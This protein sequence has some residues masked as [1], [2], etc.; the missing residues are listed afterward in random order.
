MVNEGT[1]PR[2]SRPGRRDAGCRPSAG[3][4]RPRAACACGSWTA[5]PWASRAIAR[6]PVSAGG[7]C[8]AGL[9]GLQELVHPDRLRTPMR[10]TGARGAGS[11]KEISWDE[12][13]DEIAGRLRQLREQGRP[14]AFAVLE[15]GDSPLTHA[16]LERVMGAYG[17]PNLVLDGHERGVA[18]RVELHRRRRARSGRRPCAF[19]LHPELRPRAVRDR[20]P[21][22]VAEQGVGPVCALRRCSGPPRSPGSARASPRAHR[23]PTCASPS[24]RVKRRRWPSGSCTSS[25]WKTWST[26]RS[27]SAGPTGSPRRGARPGREGFESFVTQALH[28]GG[29]EPPHGGARRARSCAWAARSA[30]RSARSRSSARPRCT[31]EDALATGVRR[32]RAQPGAGR[33]GPRGRLRCGRELAGRAARRA[34][35]PDA[36]ARTGPRGAARGR[37]RHRDAR[38]RQAQPGERLVANLAAGQALSDRRAVRARRESRCTSGR[39]ASRSRRRSRAFRCWWRSAG[40]PDETAALADIVLP[41]SSFLESWNLLPSVARAAARS[42][43]AAAAG[44]PAALREPRLRGHVVRAR[45]PRRRSHGGSGAGG[46][47]RRLA[48]RRPPR[49]CSARVAARSRP[50]RRASASRASSRRAA[51]RSRV[52]SP[53]AAFWTALRESAGWV[54]SPAVAR[55]PCEVLGRGSERFSF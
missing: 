40:V 18:R 30:R 23:A 9:A 10:R 16:W 5:C 17:S 1:L 14:Q 50:A 19:G 38:R 11:W 4:A 31:R 54:D 24:A 27:S 37:C 26:A 42:R 51:G 12:A 41:E 7:L 3:C 28:A 22:G 33:R 47:V 20:R 15:R 55:S 13:L 44:G 45:A 52:R 53:A 39:T 6:I 2:A 46:N 32:G 49:G 29:G 48:A 21:S 25:S 8:P 34:L 43:G 36:M 35:E